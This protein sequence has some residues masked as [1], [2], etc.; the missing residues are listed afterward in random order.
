MTAARFRV[1]GWHVLA[2]MLAFFGAIIAVNAAFAVIAIRSFPGEDVR[3]SYLQGIQFNQTL[4][5]RRAQAALGWRAV[6]A[7]RQRD[8][9][10]VLEVTLRQRDG[11]PIT[12]ASI[13]GEMQWPTTASFDRDLTFTPLGDGRY[14]ARLGALEHGRWR[15]RARAEAEAGALDFESEMTWPS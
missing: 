2:A 5:A 4:E 8:G 6:T 14:E 10:A 3:R 11:Q 15:L 9:E 12:A 7:L 13:T 1:R